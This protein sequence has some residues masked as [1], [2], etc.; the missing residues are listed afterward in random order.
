[1]SSDTDLIVAQDITKTYRAGIGRARV[2]EMLP[3]PLDRVVSKLFPT[4]W[5]RDTFNAL[6][7][8]SLSIRKGTSVG[9]VGHNGAGKTTLL[10]VIAGVTAPTRGTVELKGR[11]G[12]VI[13]VLVGFQGDLTGR[14]NIALIGAAHG[15]GKRTVES[16][17]DDVLQFAE[18]EELADTPMKRYST[19]MISRLGFAAVTV[20]DVDIL[21]VDEILVV[22]DASFQRKCVRWLD[23]YRSSGGTL[24]VVSHNLA[25][26]RSMTERVVWLDH[27]RVAADAPTEQALTLYAEAMQRRE[28]ATAGHSTAREDLRRAAVAH[29]LVRWGAGGARVEEVTFNEPTD[30]GRALDVSIRFTSEASNRAV[31]SIGFVDETGREVGSATSPPVALGPGEATVRC[32]IRPLPLRP[33]IYFP[34]TQIISTDGVV[35]DQWSLDRAVVVDHDGSDLTAALGPIEIGAAWS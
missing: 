18:L 22:G 26:I 30:H 11:L 17:L 7:D 31:F 4:W 33:G 2:R 28:P 35:R 24:L 13:N 14:E 34:V 23:A 15:F 1:M 12:A 10:K 9:L 29:G 21:L 3:S 6:Q 8:V 20:L 32:A 25:L 16:R 5:A 19:G 27:G